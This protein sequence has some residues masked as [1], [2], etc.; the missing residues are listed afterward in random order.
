MMDHTDP[1]RSGEALALG[2]ATLHEAFGRKGHLPAGLRPVSPDTR[3][4]GP[5]FTVRCAPG[6]NLWIHRAVY[7][8]S[9]GDVLVV[10]TG[11]TAALWG[12]W[13]EILAVAAI[14]VGLGGLVLQGGSRD[15]DALT[16][17]DFP[18]FSLGPCIKGT[19]KEAASRTGG[20]DTP[21]V[22]GETTVHPGDLV[23]GDADG[24][25]AIAAG[26]L[27]TV[28]T[29]GRARVDKEAQVL[30]LLRQGASTLDLYDLR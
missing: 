17:L 13:G 28:L 2:S 18:V 1:G 9:P 21:V 24:V 4:A 22:L 12:Y 30:Q 26:E 19:V 3:L 23:V 8:A 6:D 29:A 11:D 10:A 15:H 5:A 14:S 27:E 7:A 20:L 16:S 25:V